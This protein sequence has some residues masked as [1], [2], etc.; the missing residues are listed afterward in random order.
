VEDVGGVLLLS[1]A[2]SRDWAACCFAI[3]V[4]AGQPSLLSNCTYLG[5]TA[6]VVCRT[7]HRVYLVIQYSQ[8]G[9]SLGSPEFC[10]W[11]GWYMGHDLVCDW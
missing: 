8:V 5:L 2:A 7:I 6:G 11:G 3:I 10:E 4:D 9:Y 1:C